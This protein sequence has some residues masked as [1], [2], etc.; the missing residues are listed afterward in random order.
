MSSLL[1]NDALQTVLRD[2]KTY[3]KG[4]QCDPPPRKKWKIFKQKKR[5]KRF[6]M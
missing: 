2:N 5:R 3:A 4:Q 1:Y 6:L